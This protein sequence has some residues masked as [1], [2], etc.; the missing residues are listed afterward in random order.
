MAQAGLLEVA[1]ERQRR[2]A[3]ERVYRV[4]AR[5][6]ALDPGSLGELSAEPIGGDRFSA[7]YLVALA[8]RAIRELAALMARA[9]SSGKRLATTGVSTEVRLAE[10]GDFN[11]LAEDLSRAV[12]EVVARYNAGG[13]EGRT[14]RVFLGAYPGPA[15]TME[16]EEDADER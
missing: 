11:A 3:K 9:R 1:E 15:R 12:A 4:V 6:F 5:Q 14:F 10:P 16:Q 8:S 7:T 13:G 2:G